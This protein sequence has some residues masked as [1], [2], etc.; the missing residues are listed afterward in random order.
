[1]LVLPS[2][3]KGTHDTRKT[4]HANLARSIKELYDVKKVYDKG[5]CDKENLRVRVMIRTEYPAGE[6]TLRLLT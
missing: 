3:R 2:S 1:M 4:R 5:A 6:E